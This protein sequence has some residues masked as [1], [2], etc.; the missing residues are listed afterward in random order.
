MKYFISTIILL[1]IYFMPDIITFVEV[2]KCL[3]KGNSYD[4]QKQQ[5]IG[6]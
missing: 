3:D 6:E 5:C 2:D 1:L 4:Y